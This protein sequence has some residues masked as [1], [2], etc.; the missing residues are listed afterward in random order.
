[1]TDRMETLMAAIFVNQ[2]PAPWAKL[3][4]PSTRGLASWLDNLRQRL[5]QLNAWKDD[6]QRKPAVT[7]LN[8]LFNPQSFLTAIKQVHA[9]ESGLELNVLT[10][11]TEV[12]KKLY[13]EADLPPSKEGQGAYVFGLQV[14]GA[15]WDAAAGQLE[16]LLYD[17]DWGD[18]A[19][20]PWS[21]TTIRAMEPSR[22]ALT[23]TCGGTPARR[24]LRAF[25]MRLP[26]NCPIWVRS[27]STSPEHP[28]MSINASVS[29]T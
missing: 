28:E 26:S 4:F 2:V 10:I 20:K 17:V 13:W 6:P 14:D 3:G 11:N 29:A 12:L 25:S 7:F 8:R 22:A 1:M 21:R 16:Q 9:R 18:D 19:P 15:R 27:A 23:S 24:Y 5:D